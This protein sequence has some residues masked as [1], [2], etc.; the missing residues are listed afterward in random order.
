MEAES[1]KGQLQLLQNGQS[2]H[3]GKRHIVSCSNN[4]EIFGP[5][6]RHACLVMEA[7]GSNLR[8]FNKAMW[9]LSPKAA[10]EVL[11]QLVVGVSYMHELGV[12]HGGMY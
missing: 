6:G 4:F 3:V 12:T 2:T 10:W 5:N 9:E 7:L 11:K 1:E 8:G